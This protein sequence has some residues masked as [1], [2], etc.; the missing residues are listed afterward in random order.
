MKKVKQRVIAFSIF[1]IL[2]LPVWAAAASPE[3]ST[4]GVGGYD[5]VAYFK[6]GKAMKGNGWHVA[7][8]QGVTYVFA[9]KK[10]RKMFEADPGKYLPAYGGYC[11]YGVA[12]GQK[13]VADPEVWKIVEGSLYLNLDQDIQRKWNK[14][15][16]GYIQKA[17]A[18]WMKIRDKAA[19]DL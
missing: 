14:D 13:F 6:S 7:Y 15:I 9:S 17:D 4:V 16:P 8:H 18:N 10:N 12:V 19:A 3:E 1:M 11:A 2:G 5:P